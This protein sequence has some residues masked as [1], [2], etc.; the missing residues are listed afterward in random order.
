LPR[1]QAHRDAVAYPVDTGRPAA[2]VRLR[3]TLQRRVGLSCR[4]GP[5]NVPSTPCVSQRNAA[6]LAVRRQAGALCGPLGAYRAGRSEPRVSETPP[7]VRPLASGLE[8]RLRSWGS[9]FRFLNYCQELI[10]RFFRSVVLPGPTSGAADGS[11]ADRGMSFRATTLAARTDSRTIVQCHRLAVRSLERKSHRSH[12]RLKRT[13]VQE[14]ARE[15]VRV[16]ATP[17]VEDAE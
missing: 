16:A 8:F 14:R 5:L 1:G 4:V 9:V 10:E 12:D 17:T 2:G 3:Q 11:A 13:P 6:A 15:N 7:V